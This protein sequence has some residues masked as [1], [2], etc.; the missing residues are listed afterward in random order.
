MGRQS[1]EG[2]NLGGSS[3]TELKKEKGRFIRSNKYAR[4]D[5]LFSESG[6]NTGKE[7]IN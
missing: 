7:R 5:K 4:L 2:Q 3:R 6:T 1:N